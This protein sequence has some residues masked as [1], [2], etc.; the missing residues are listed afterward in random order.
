MK[1]CQAIAPLISEYINGTLDS[2]DV[3]MV[4]SHIARC[5]PCALMAAEFQTLT[6]LLKKVPERTPTSSF[7]E[8]LASRIASLPQ[9]SPRPR[10]SLSIFWQ[11]MGRSRTTVLRSAIA[12]ASACAAVLG[13]FL[14]TSRGPNTTAFEN[15]ETPLLTHCIE[16]HRIDSAAQPLSDLSVQDVSAR[17]DAQNQPSDALSYG[18]DQD[19]L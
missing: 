13:I 3:W 14:V 11:D 12:L 8:K 17:Q 6:Q 1:N 2:K 5:E 7:D 4:Q 16:Q 18:D 10:F 9:P 15:A 19:N